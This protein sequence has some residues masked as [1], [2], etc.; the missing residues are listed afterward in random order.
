VSIQLACVINATSCVA[1]SIYLERGPEKSPIALSLNPCAPP[2][3]IFRPYR[4]LAIVSSIA[5]RKVVTLR[6]TSTPI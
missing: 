2:P 6:L 4:S 5:L 1:G 3:R